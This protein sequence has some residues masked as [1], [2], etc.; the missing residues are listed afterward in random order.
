MLWTV[1]VVKAPPVVFVTAYR[2]LPSH[3]RAPE[4]YFE[5]G[6][7]LL[8]TGLPFMVF[9]ESQHAARFGEFPAVIRTVV[10]DEP[11]VG[12]R[13]G[14]TSPRLPATDNPSKDTLEYHCL[15]HRKTRYLVESYRHLQQIYQEQIYEVV[16]LVWIDFGIFHLPGVTEA[17][18]KQLNER[19]GRDLSR[20]IRAPSAWRLDQDSQIDSGRIQWY[21]LG[22]LL[23][24]P[25]RPARIVRELAERVETSF[26][27]RILFAHQACFEVVT[28]ALDAQ[29]RPESWDL[30]PA[31]HN[32]TLFTHYPGR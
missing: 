7:R 8:S 15:M 32:Q 30:Y 26:L 13:V 20:Q 16:R 23:S 12:G 6:S 17:H 9:T 25:T 5:L 19:C 14:I 27:S 3:P 1:S 24:V 18:L 22:G 2:S 21:L 28:W 11:L 4:K 31:D 10:D 29:N